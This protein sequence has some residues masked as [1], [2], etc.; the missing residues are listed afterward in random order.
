[1][2]TRLFHHALIINACWLLLVFNPV[3]AAEKAPEHSRESSVIL[4][5]RNFDSP[6]VRSLVK[7][8][9]KQTPEY[10]HLQILRSPEMSQ[11][12]A[13]HELAKSHSDIVHVAN[14]ASSVTRE[15]E[16]HAIPIPIDGGLL[17]LRVCIVQKA[18]LPLFK[19]IT[20]IQDLA[21][22]G[23][24]IGQ[25]THWPDTS[26]L[27]VNGIKVVTHSRYEILFGMIDNDRF[28]CFARGVS[29]V[30][31]DLELEQN[32]SYV[33]EPSLMLAYTM[34]SYLF[35]SRSNQELAQRLKLGIDRAIENGSFSTYLDTYY[36]RAIR[37]LNLGSRTI[38][39]LDNPYISRDSWEISQ[40]TLEELRDTIDRSLKE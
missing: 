36:G 12:R 35:V 3:C 33:I 39:A 38:L 21:D 5:Y 23:I 17:G 34:P 18:D 28:E 9:L 20:S 24:R 29:E 6:Q 15:K 40:K 19:D 22:S 10:G 2:I 13:I 7:L 11:G 16:L 14:V 4:W 30:L 25:G 31:Y 1:M 8:A 32:D 27:Q 26:V 37:E